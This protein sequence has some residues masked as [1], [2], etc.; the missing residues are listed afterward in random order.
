[1]SNSTDVTMAVFGVFPSPPLR[2]RSTYVRPKTAAVAAKT[3]P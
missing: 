2:F 3:S 1:M